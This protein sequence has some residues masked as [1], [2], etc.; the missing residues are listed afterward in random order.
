VALL[1]EDRQRRGAAA[2]VGADD[3]DT[4]ASRRISPALGERRLYSA[5]TEMP[6]S[7]SASENGP[8]LAGAGGALLELGE[9]DVS[10]AARPRP[11]A[12]RR[13][14]ARGRSSVRELPRQLEVGVGGAQRGTRVDRLAGGLDALAQAVGQPAA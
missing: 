5:M 9:R 11:R 13:R 3:L 12:W 2:L 14:C 10:P 6:G 1:G 7:V 8:V 4:V